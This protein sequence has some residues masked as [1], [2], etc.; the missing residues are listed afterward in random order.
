[1]ETNS[2]IKQVVYYLVFGLII[3]LLTF[4]KYE[5]SYGTGLDPS[6]VWALNHLFSN[7]YDALT[8][9]IY[10]IGPLG[11]L[12]YSAAFDNNLAYALLFFSIFKLTFI[13]LLLRLF[14]VTRKRYDPLSLLLTLTVS[15]FAGFDLTIIGSVVIAL[16]L[17]LQN[18]RNHAYFI[19]ANLLAAFGLMVK[20]SIGI[21]AYSIF[22]SYYF[23]Y[24][25]LE[26][27]A[28]KNFLTQ[29]IITVGVLLVIGITV[30]KGVISFFSFMIGTTHLAGGY[31]SGLAL[32]PENNWWLL[33]C[34]II[35]LLSFPFLS[36]D[37]G[38]R[39]AWLLLLLP[40]FATWKLAMGR[41]DFFHYSA[42]ISFLVVF[43]A[44]ILANTKK[45]NLWVIVFPFLTLFLFYVNMNNLPGSHSYR[46]NLAGYNNFNEAVINYSEFNTEYHSISES[47]VSKNKLDMETRAVIGNRTI[48]IYPWDLSY[49]AANQLNWIPRKTLEL[50]ASTS[51]WLS[52]KSASHF[53]GDESPDFV[54]FHLK[55]DKWGGNLGSIDGRYIL[56]DEPLVISNLLRYYKIRHKND[57][58][59]LF[60]KLN[61]E[62]DAVHSETLEAEA[63]RWNEWIAVPEQENNLI[64][65]KIGVRKNLLG[66]LKTFMYKDEAFYIDYRLFDGRILTYRFLSST[67]VDGLWVNPLIK[68]PSTGTIAKVKKIRIRCTNQAMVTD[69]FSLSWELIKMKPGPAAP[70]FFW[71]PEHTN[72]QVIFQ[73][74]LDYQTKSP[75]WAIKPQQR[76]FPESDNPAEEIKSKGY[77]SSFSISTDS[78]LN[79]ESKQLT[80]EAGL[81]YRFKETS[82]KGASLVMSIQG[83]DEDFW[84]S[85][86]LDPV[87]DDEW[88]YAFKMAE[89]SYGSHRGGALKVY[90]WNNSDVPVI[91]D[92]FRICIYTD[93]I[94]DP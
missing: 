29:L 18:D 77:S 45:R 41:E 56:N 39:R 72:R 34:F 13:F 7:D 79:Q 24:V 33:S 68:D 65:A 12:K 23:L 63:G 92:D 76:I 44:I 38:S 71:Y 87:S 15:Y 88:K 91:I 19:I 84:K 37:K 57:S 80:I 3:F 27:P 81:S 14:A 52:G 75:G 20:S 46:V 89:L 43:W 47:K 64:R 90:L 49:A 62:S 58:F 78:L 22:F 59:L 2:K 55:K 83:T 17:H 32:F 25:V 67:A 40:F 94:N 31:S 69:D 35:L 10:P 86:P 48:D 93:T 21:T 8:Q 66:T 1:M 51:S 28:L 42:M 85:F 53:K 61:Q 6:Y 54:L 70:D 36:K 26:R 9:L 73:S 30:Q 50:G 16:L 5:P 4:P 74:L 60:E 82:A 11:F